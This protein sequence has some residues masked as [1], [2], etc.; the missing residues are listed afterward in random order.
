MPSEPECVNLSSSDE[1]DDEP[2]SKPGTKTADGR[3]KG[4]EGE[5]RRFEFSR[6]FPLTKIEMSPTELSELSEIRAKMET[7]TLGF[8][9]QL[10]V[11]ENFPLA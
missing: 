2:G 7:L 8:I 3:S 1:E 5:I 10:G 4:G 9:M 11:A 6:R